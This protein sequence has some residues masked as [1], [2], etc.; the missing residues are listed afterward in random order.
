MNKESRLN[1]CIKEL[2]ADAQEIA[3][4]DIEFR[5]TDFD[6]FERVMWPDDETRCR[7]D[8]DLDDFCDALREAFDQWQR[9]ARLWMDADDSV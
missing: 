4:D 5:M 2:V 1:S 3:R 9:R 6:G 7:Y 8:L